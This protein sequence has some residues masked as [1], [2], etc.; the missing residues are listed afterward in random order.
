MSTPSLAI[1]TGANSGFGFATA[2]ELC[3]RGY[4][5]VCA[6]RTEATGS[7]AAAAISSTVKL[8]HGTAVFMQLDVSDL[9]SVSAF[10]DAFKTRYAGRKLDLLILNAG[11]AMP[12]RSFSPQGFEMTAATNHFGHAALFNVLLDVLRASAPCRVVSVASSLHA[13]GRVS[14]EDLEQLNA[15]FFSPVGIYSNTKL[16]NVIWSAE[17]E[18]RFGSEGI[19][20]NS[21]HPG[22]D[23]FTGIYRGLPLLGRL[24]LRALAPLMFLTGSAQTAHQGAKAEL[25]AALAPAGGKYYYRSWAWTPSGRARN[26]V[27]S[28]WLWT[29]TQRRLAQAAASHG[30]PQSLALPADD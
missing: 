18:R 11:V 28:V 20:C 27:V 29:E 24:A 25:A 14:K 1:V 13:A 30:L 22:S 5:V 12:S 8:G 15:R 7:A 9:A 16:F 2:Q 19:T 6:C 3:R 10:A 17:V 26:P 23:A 21:V 4:E